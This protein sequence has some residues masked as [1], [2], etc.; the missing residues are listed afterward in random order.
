MARSIETSDSAY[1][2]YCR[3]KGIKI[4]GTS[5]DATLFDLTQDAAQARNITHA[6]WVREALISQVHEEGFEYLPPTPANLKEVVAT[7]AQRIAELEAKL[8]KQEKAQAR[9]ERRAPTPPT[10]RAN[11][12][13]GVLEPQA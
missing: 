9:A 10:Q 6:A 2:Q 4:L 7:Q 1:A 12:E 3:E 11:P 5:L 13:S 8:A